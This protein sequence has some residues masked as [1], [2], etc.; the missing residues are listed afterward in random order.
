MVAVAPPSD[1]TGSVVLHF[2]HFCR[3][4]CIPSGSLKEVSSIPVVTGF[5]YKSNTSTSIENGLP[6]TRCG[7]AKGRGEAKVGGRVR[8]KAQRKAVMRELRG[9]HALPFLNA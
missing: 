3:S 6:A 4:N 9:V 2:A 1:V 8:A 7:K 5:P